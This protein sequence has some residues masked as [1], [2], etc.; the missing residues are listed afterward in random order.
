MAPRRSPLH[1]AIEA[2]SPT[3]GELHGMQVAARMPDD[4]T[5]KPIALADASCLPRMGVKGPQAEAWLRGQGVAVP[6]GVNAWTRTPDGMIV[7]RLARSEFFL[8]DRPGGATV[9]RLRSALMPGPGLYPVLRQDAALALAGERFN[10]LLVQTC[11]V[12]FRAWTLSQR[13]VVMTSMVGVSVLVLWHEQQGRPLFRIWCDGTFGPYL[14]E[15]LLEIARE[16]GGG[17]A[18]FSGLFPDATGI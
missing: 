3:W 2:Q 16:E 7:A 11:N 4:V 10:E 13:V 17:A 6:E 9:E 12:D 1:D 15:T 8:E 18:G 5:A 14:W